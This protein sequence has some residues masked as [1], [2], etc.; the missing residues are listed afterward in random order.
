MTM[1]PWSKY[2]GNKNY[3]CLKEIKCKIRIDVKELKQ[4]DCSKTSNNRFS[5]W[6][7]AWPN[8]C[9]NSTQ[10]LTTLLHDVAAFVEW[11]GQTYATYRNTVAERTQHVVP[12]NVARCCVEMLRAFGQALPKSISSRRYFNNS[13]NEKNSFTLKQMYDGDAFFKSFVIRHLSGDTL[14]LVAARNL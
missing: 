13:L 5:K 11:T 3:I 14:S 9:N 2:N 8:A 1:A 10:H 6:L 4:D 7:K 12:N